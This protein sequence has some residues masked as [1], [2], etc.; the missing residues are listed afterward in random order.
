RCA[1]CH[2]TLR[3]LQDTRQI[4]KR[5]DALEIPSDE[6]FWNEYT[7]AVCRTVPP[8]PSHDDNVWWAWPAS[9]VL[10]L[11]SLL[12]LFMAI[13]D[14]SWHTA[15]EPRAERSSLSE[16][17]HSGAAN[18]TDAVGSDLEWEGLDIERYLYTQSAFYENLQRELSL[19]RIDPEI[20]T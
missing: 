5:S 3:D 17:A 15:P 8:V 2:E 4:V 19:L 18:P 16:A 6:A 7:Q 11:S 14:R 10:A 9:L 1:L 13:W 20:W 12:L